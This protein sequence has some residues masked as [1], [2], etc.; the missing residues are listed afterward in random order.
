MNHAVRAAAV[1]IA[2]LVSLSA[3]LMHTSAA[4]E[5]IVT[6]MLGL[7]APPPPNP[8]VK[9]SATRAEGFYNRS[10]P[11]KDDASIDDLIDYW[12]NMS[13]SYTRLRYMPEPD[14]RSMSRIRKQIENDPKKL[15][16]LL[17][18]FRTPK[19]G[20]EFVKDIYDAQGANGVFEKET[21]DQIRNWLVYNSPYFSNEL[22]AGAQK[23]ADSN[24]YV[25]NQE[26]L[27][28]LANVDFNKAQPL[29]DRLLAGG[30]G[31]VS[32]ALAKWALYKNALKTDSIGDIERYR[33]EL[34]AIVEDK[35]N[36]DGMRDLAMDAL[37]SEKEW[38]GR[39]DWYFTLMSDE[40]LVK[41][42]RFTGLTTLINVSPDEKYIEKMIDLLKSNDP[43]V[44]GAAIRNLT[45]K[46]DTGNV[47]IIRALLP[48]LEDANWAVDAGTSRETIVRKLADIEMPEAVPGLIKMLD[49]KAKRPNYAARAAMAAN[50]TSVEIRPATPTMAPAATSA[51]SVRTVRAD[52]INDSD[53][54]EVAAF[55]MAAVQALAKQKDG[56]AAPALRRML[57]ETQ[58]YERSQVV[59]AILLCNGFTIPE[60]LDALEMSAKGLRAEMDEAEAAALNSSSNTNAM[61]SVIT[62]TIT[63]ANTAAYAATNVPIKKILTP[64]LLKELLASELQS[65]AEI[66]D[67]LASA[68]V[69]RIEQLD[70][71]DQRQT[72]AYRKMAMRWQNSIINS[73]FLLDVRN[74]RSDIDSVIRL[75]SQRVALRE[76]QSSD[77]QALQSGSP[78]AQ[79]FAACMLDDP[80]LYLS[81]LDGENLQTRTAMY[82]CAR[83]IRAQ[84][85]VAKVGEDLKSSDKRLAI[86]AERYLQSEDSPEARSLVLARHPGEAWITGAS[87]AFYVDGATVEYSEYM[88]ALYGSVGDNSIYNGWVGSEDTDLKAKE[89][90]LQKE[91]LATEDLNGVYAYDSNYI[92]IYRDRIIFSWDEDENRYRERALTQYEFEQLKTYLTDQ[93]VDSLKPFL[94]CGGEYCVNAQLLMLGKNG[95]RRVYRNGTGYA[96]F[97]GLDKYFKQLKETPAVV[98]YELSRQIPGLE[99]VLIDDSFH[100]ETVWHQGSDLIVAGSDMEVRKRVDAE[101]EKTVNGEDGEGGVEVDDKYAAKLALDAKRAFE[102]VSWRSVTNG[103]LSG[104]IA[105]PVDNEYIPRADSLAAPAEVDTW[106]SR[107]GNV[108][109]RASVEG[110][111]KVSQGR[112]TKVKDGRYHS[113]VIMPNGRNMLVGKCVEEY[114]CK[115]YRLDTV[116]A[117]EVEV[118][119]EG[120]GRAVPTAF[121][122]SVNKIL[123]VRRPEYE[124]Y[125]DR[126]EDRAP[127]DPEPE[128]MYFVDAITGMVVPAK[129]EF[130][131]L[132]QQDYRPLQKTARPNE[133]W[134]AIMDT[135]SGSTEVGVFDA[136]FFTFK[137]VIR[138]PKI[139]FNSMDMYVDEAA[140]KVYF[141]YRGHLLSVPFKGT[142]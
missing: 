2:L 4:K 108:E 48:W 121:V 59:R 78:T 10:K 45:L 136:K 96:F 5:D 102:G 54:D 84:L 124:Y 26:E 35:K 7:P 94:G 133:F 98:K 132:S 60:Q 16:G 118:P 49:E 100:V 72:Q 114:D 22:L 56:R 69:N 17:N 9:A 109:Y 141:V 135:E 92:R 57:N 82:A 41:M 86:A 32:Y 28:A 119:I 65:S 39:D 115:L 95:G 19:D 15:P 12:I 91:I 105:A 88:Y 122:A 63:S 53:E 13:E 23:V 112:I 55:R 126:D 90:A 138:L 20:F 50:G 106:K 44:R 99:L 67:A 24:D 128:S 25:T 1:C 34:K 107:L 11:P 46:L 37:V 52:S 51:G 111:F 77:V 62:S 131:P 66:S 42:E 6:R 14:D 103:T 129:G 130:R 134:A 79:G 33:D 68:L 81:I 139:Q 140:R 31:T 89:K 70:K 85:P 43:L 76:K 120:F 104:E 18:L 27:L 29:I 142:P 137:P 97:D 47:E 75:L 74:D 21:R 73:L 116:T 71:S 87:T 127:V 123:V 36:V 101:I 110:L 58:D 40:T 8:L 83:M 125:M 30:S 61:G 3:F 64:A 117:K 38:P 113:P 93:E 80:S